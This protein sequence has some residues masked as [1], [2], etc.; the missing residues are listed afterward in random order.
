MK[1]KFSRKEILGWVDCQ[2]WGQSADWTKLRSM[3]LTL[4]D[5]P[6]EE[7]LKIMKDGKKKNEELA[8]KYMSDV[9]S[10]LIWEGGVNHDPNNPFP[11]KTDKPKEEC[12]HSHVGYEGGERHCFGCGKLMPTPLNTKPE[13]ERLDPYD[14]E[15]ALVETVNE[16]I[17]R[18]NLLSPKETINNQ[19]QK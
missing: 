19:K 7:I 13:I 6:K 14:Y 8:Q 10:N 17:D 18:V 12:E 3:I 1:Y 15:G 4:A 2:D 16:L 5:K 9:A 11:L